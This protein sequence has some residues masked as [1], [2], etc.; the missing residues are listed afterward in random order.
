MKQLLILQLTDKILSLQIVPNSRNVSS[1]KDLELILSE[2]R[3]AIVE[4]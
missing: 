2:S 3:V 1:S 4:A